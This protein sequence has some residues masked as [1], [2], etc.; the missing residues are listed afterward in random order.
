MTVLT[1]CKDFERESKE[2]WDKRLEEGWDK[3]FHSM[4]LDPEEE[5]KKMDRK[6]LS[7]FNQESARVSAN[8]HHASD[9]QMSLWKPS[10]LECACG[11]GRYVPLLGDRVRAYQGIDLGDLNIEEAKKL[12][13]SEKFRF[14]VG[15]M[16]TFHTEEKFDIIFAVSAG[17]SIERNF[18]EIKNNLKSMLAPG[19]CIIFFEQDRYMVI[20][21]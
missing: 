1:D 15:D 5:I 3:P 14:Q 4:F 13:G 18:V 20:W 19:G 17:S 10:V 8:N 16:L 21:G 6:N 9:L 12:Y 7:I 11:A 2:Y